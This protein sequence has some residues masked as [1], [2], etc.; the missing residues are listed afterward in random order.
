MEKTHV[1]IVGAGPVGLFTAYLLA[2]QKIKCI[3]LERRHGVSEHPKAHTIN[4]R[5]LEIFRQAGLDVA[6]I[7]KYAAGARDAGSVRLVY[8]LADAEIGSFPYERQDDEVRS[9]TPEPLVNWPQ[10]E[11]ERL[12]Q[13]SVIETGLVHI[14]RGWQVDSVN[15]MTETTGVETGCVCVVSCS[16]SSNSSNSN[17]SSTRLRRDA[18]GDTTRHKCIQADFVI[19]ADGV[20]STVREKMGGIEFQSMGPGYAYQSVIY[21]GSLRSALPAD[22]EAMLY[23]CFHPDHP[24]QFIAHRLDTSFVH[25]TPVMD[26]V[27]LPSAGAQQRKAAAARS[28]PEACL[29]G[30]RYTEVLRTIWE[31]APRVASSY[32]D[33]KHGR[34][35][36]VGD[37]AHSLPPQGGLGLNTGI[38]DAH[39]LVWKLVSIMQNKGNSSHLLSSYTRE[40]RP[41]ALANLEYSKASEAAFYSVSTTLVGVAV[42]YQEARAEVPG[43]A[44]DAFL[45]QPVVCAGVAGAVAEASQHFDSLALQLGFIYDDDPSSTRPLLD[46]PTRYVPRACPGAR[47]PHGM[48]SGENDDGH[49][50]GRLLSLL[51]LV[52]YD[53]FT[54]L[55]HANPVFASCDWAIDVA[56]LGMPEAWHDAVP[57]IKKGKGIVVRPDLHVLLHVDNPRQAE[58]AVAEYLDRGEVRRIR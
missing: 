48:I 29:P 21:R 34:V 10:P 24:S 12:L 50:D 5:T 51:D 33:A 6:Y 22:R 42:Q 49:R 38:A 56:G 27:P 47:L 36:L 25:V 26:T 55:H 3:V 39:N 13:K 31:T 32:S 53:R 14:R 35:F 54:V 28:S 16:S 45:Q 40:R 43:L 15:M 41:V 57:E 8:G 7:R 46:N 4:P 52:P 19:G 30:L 23:F 9:L 1:V 44:M 2:R 58:D 18:D 37:A 11:L 20:N 17:T